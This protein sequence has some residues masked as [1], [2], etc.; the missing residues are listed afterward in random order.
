MKLLLHAANKITD[1]VEPVICN[2]CQPVTHLYMFILYLKL[3]YSNFRAILFQDL[4]F[5]NDKEEQNM[6]MDVLPYLMF[7]L[8]KT[9]TKTK[10][11]YCYTVEQIMF[12]IGVAL[13]HCIVL[14]F[15]LSHTTY[16]IKMNT[17]G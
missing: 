7:I 4:T 12:K 14:D 6:K 1:I 2:C 3:I 10:I 16:M 17:L 5:S 8:T 9:N 11:Q 13:D 15:D